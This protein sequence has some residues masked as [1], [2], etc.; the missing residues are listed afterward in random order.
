MT[1]LIRTVGA[2]LLVGVTAFCVFGFLAASEAPAD[3]I[4]WFRLM[5]GVVGIVS[6]GTA[7]YLVWP[8]SSRDN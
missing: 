5:Y 2:V 6:V 4:V 8:R 3:S 7:V 1:K